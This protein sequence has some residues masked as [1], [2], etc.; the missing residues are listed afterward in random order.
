MLDD[1]FTD[2]DITV[3]RKR[4]LS[5][6]KHLLEMF[7]E[8][9]QTSITPIELLLLYDIRLWKELR[10]HLREI[11][12]SAMLSDPYLKKFYALRYANLYDRISIPFMKRD[13]EPELNMVFFSVQLFTT[14]SLATLLASQCDI[15]GVILEILQS[16]LTSESK[17]P[18]HLSEDVPPDYQVDCESSVLGSRRYFHFFHDLRYLF[19]TD[20]VRRH[21]IQTPT[22][23]LKFLRFVDTF[24]GMDP[25]RR[26]LHTHV[27]YESNTW[28]NA[29]NLTFTLAQG[30]SLF[31]TALSADETGDICRNAIALAI[32]K[33][34]SRIQVSRHFSWRPLLLS[35]SHHP[36]PSLTFRVSMQAISFHHTMH[37]FTSGALFQ[38]Y[39]SM[40]TR[41][42]FS[43]WA[44]TFDSPLAAVPIGFNLDRKCFGIMILMEMPLRIRVLFAQVRAGL[45]VRNGYS[46]RNQV[47]QMKS[48]FSVMSV[49][50]QLSRG[51]AARRYI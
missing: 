21:L 34:G 10:L 44:E 19:S 18:V 26:A 1:S 35:A 50:V 6:R 4:K 49:G 12:V 42:D 48:S 40:S 16:Y 8:H 14:P 15:V 45:W 39:K 32:S 36:V 43:K 46:I 5:F 37:W 47:R 38:L 51:V 28:V 2:Q 13:R 11:Y 3:D 17:P 41:N 31:A 27:E 23:V 30:I 7:P 20:G 29:F 24:A 25:T 22:L 9:Q 33:I